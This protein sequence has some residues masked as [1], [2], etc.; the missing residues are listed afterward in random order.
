MMMRRGGTDFMRFV[1][2]A[3]APVEDN[4]SI[5]YNDTLGPSLSKI[6]VGKIL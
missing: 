5:Q 2:A 6:L 4:L 3:A 1:V